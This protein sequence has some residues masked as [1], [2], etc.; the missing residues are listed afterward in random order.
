MFRNMD[1]LDLL[2]GIELNVD[3]INIQDIDKMIKNVWSEE[4]FGLIIYKII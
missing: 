2:F 3:R 1:I 4:F